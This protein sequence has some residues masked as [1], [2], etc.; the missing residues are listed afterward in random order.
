MVTRALLQ[1]EELI[2]Q[3]L[4]LGALPVPVPTIQTV[5]P[6]E[7]RS[8][9]EAIHNLHRYDWI[10]FSSA[11][12]VV[13]FFRRLSALGAD[14]RILGKIKMATVGAATA[15]KL[16]EFGFKSDL[17]PP[18]FVA[19]SLLQAFSGLLKQGE[20]ILILRPQEA[21]ATLREG[22]QQAGLYV[23]E[24]VAYRTVGV[25]VH[26][27]AWLADLAGRGADWLIFTSPSTVRHFA[28]LFPGGVPEP[29]LQTPA[30]CIGPVTRRAAET[31]GFSRLFV[32]DR[33]S[34]EGIVQLLL[35]ETAKRQP[36]AAAVRR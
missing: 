7:N 10:V 17:V 19:E 26:P 20:R 24:A 12:G 15:S 9:D 27:A 4:A 14:L 33:F 2:S 3:L 32:P 34:S 28:A 22:L 13:H 1:A 31:A 11:N 6:R 18:R 16:A 25:P 36:A 5:P 29:L 8:I 21:R 35:R 23:D 30:V